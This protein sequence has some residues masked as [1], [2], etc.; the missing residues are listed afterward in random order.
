MNL[1]SIHCIT[2]GIILTALC[3]AA[4]F[5]LSAAPKN[6]HINAVMVSASVVQ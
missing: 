4:V 5:H 3:I 1:K 2:L 6:R